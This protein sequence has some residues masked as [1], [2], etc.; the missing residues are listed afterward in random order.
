MMKIIDDTVEK[1][2][3]SSLFVMWFDKD[4]IIIREGNL[5]RHL[6]TSLLHS[7]IQ[8]LFGLSS[9]IFKTGKCN[10]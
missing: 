4:V 1:T 2:G 9:F 5:N 8:T 7:E 6:N 3:K 10:D